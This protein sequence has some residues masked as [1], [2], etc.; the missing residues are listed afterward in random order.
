[1]GKNPRVCDNPIINGRSLFPIKTDETLLQHSNSGAKPPLLG[2]ASE[3]N[4][5]SKQFMIIR[6][7]DST[8]NGKVY[9]HEHFKSQQ[10]S[11][12]LNRQK[13]AKFKNKSVSYHTLNKKS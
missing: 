8:K 4:S 10:K 3:T 1:M 13:M 9:A 7:S 11:G 2:G 12:Y 5:G 6:H